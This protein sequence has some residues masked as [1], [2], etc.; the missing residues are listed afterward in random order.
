[1]TLIFDKDTQDERRLVVDRIYFRVTEGVIQGVYDKQ[2]E[3][4]SDIPDL[5]DF[6]NK[7]SFSKLIIL[8]NG[9]E[10]PTYNVNYIRDITGNLYDKNYNLTI[11]IGDG[12]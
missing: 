7:P 6:I 8:N 4:A 2:I 11:T 10:I 12:E 3:S 1:M 5:T 9:I